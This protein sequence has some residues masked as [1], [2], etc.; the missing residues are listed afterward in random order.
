[1]WSLLPAD[2]PLPSQCWQELSPN[3]LEALSQTAQCM[4]AYEALGEEPCPCRAEEPNPGP[5][6]QEKANS[7]WHPPRKRVTQT[8]CYWEL[9]ILGSFFAMFLRAM[10]ASA[11]ILMGRDAAAVPWIG[12]IF[13]IGLRLLAWPALPK[14]FRSRTMSS[15]SDLATA[16]A[17]S[18]WMGCEGKWEV[19]KS[20]FS[21][22]KIQ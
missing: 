16:S 19:R 11:W 20:L 6:L 18:S 14:T 5:N 12:R 13:V 15:V 2:S 1:M 3:P 8:L 4:Q 9:T 22:R 10:M 21:S 7:V 17:R